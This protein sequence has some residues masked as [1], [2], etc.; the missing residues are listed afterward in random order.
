MVRR[1][2]PP[3]HPL[4]PRSRSTTPSRCRGASRCSPASTSRWRPGRPC[5]SRAPTVPA[6]PAS[7][8]SVQGW[9]RS[10]PVGCG[11]SG[12]TLWGGAARS[13]AGW[14]SSPTPATST[15]TSPC[16]RT[17]GSQCAPRVRPPSGSTRPASGWASL[18]AWSGPER[19]SSRPASGGGLRSQCWSL[20]DP[21]CGCSTSRTRGST[22]RR[23][24]SSTNW[25]PRRH[26]AGATV[27]IASHESR[28]VEP[29]ASRAVTMSGGRVVG[30]R[31]LAPAGGNSLRPPVP[32][33][34]SATGSKGRVAHVA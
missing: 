23:G 19:R 9:F 6:R 24:R 7:C 14:A 30:E 5:C 15:R 34:M 22:T 2:W 26:A 8:G 17:C 31:R 10:R 29:L 21:S 12:S 27:V 16:A 13:A 28:S 32:D 4:P 1:L 18:A 25:S 3:Q 33:T 20:A 11:C